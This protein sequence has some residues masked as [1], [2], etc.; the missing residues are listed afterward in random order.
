MRIMGVG[1]DVVAVDRIRKMAL[2]DEAIL[3]ARVFGSRENA[4][5]D[6][7]TDFEKR[8]RFYASH[9]A[10]KESLFKALGTGLVRGMLWTDVEVVDEDRRSPRLVISGETARR[11]DGEKLSGRWLS[12]G[13]SGTLAVAV[14]VLTCGGDYGDE[15]SN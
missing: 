8:V 11:I 10:A 14:V 6:R 5:L 15:R 2:R 4:S 3:R 7:L 1:T 12:L 13:G 9:I